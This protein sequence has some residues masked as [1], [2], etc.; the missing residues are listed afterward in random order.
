LK[1]TALSNITL[2][3]GIKNNNSIIDEVCLVIQECIGDNCSIEIQNLSMNYIYSCCI[4]F[5]EIEFKCT[6]KKVTQIKYNLEI[7]SNSTWYNF[8]TGLINFTNLT[9]VS[10][11]NI[12]KISLDPV[13]P[14]PMSTINFTAIIT[15]DD[16]IES[17]RIIVRECM[18]G[19]CSVFGYNESLNKTINNTY[20]GQVLLTRNDA[21]QIKYH[22]EIYYNGTRYISNTTF[23]NLNTTGFN[24][25]KEA[26]EKPESTPGFEII[27]V[28]IAVVLVLFWKQKKKVT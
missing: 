25:I 16:S 28:V 3:T 18:S 9:L 4:D 24:Y 6:N 19:L 27:P 17:M 2:I 26:I 22:L 15:S 13:E 11:P 1:P 7:L 8:E 14:K 5:Y 21:T 10:E 12:I 20:N 23:Y